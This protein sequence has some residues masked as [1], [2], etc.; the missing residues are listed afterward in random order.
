MIKKGFIEIKDSSVLAGLMLHKFSPAL[1][2]IIVWLA[3]SHGFVMTESFR[4]A[5]H[6]GDVHST[7]P[8]RAVDIR[9]RCYD[10]GQAARIRDE[11]NAMWQYDSNRPQMRCAIIH[12]VGNGVHFHIQTHPNTCRRD[13]V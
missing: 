5:R 9:S 11:I 13:H 12:D 10:G 8:V 7:D 2:E 1:A 4:P 3:D 6:P